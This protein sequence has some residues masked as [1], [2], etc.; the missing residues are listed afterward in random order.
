[1]G[2]AKT[3]RRKRN[4]Q[5]KTQEG[6]SLPGPTQKR[7]GPLPAAA[8]QRVGAPM[9]VIA[10]HTK[11]VISN[12]EVF[13]TVF[14]TAKAGVVPI[15][16]GSAGLFY[17]LGSATVTSNT[18]AP[19]LAQQMNGYDKYKVRKLKFTYQPVL[20]VTTGGGI[21]LYFDSNPKAPTPSAVTSISGNMGLRAGQIFQEIVVPVEPNQLSRLPEYQVVTVDEAGKGSAEVAGVGRLCWL[22]TATTLPNA[23][24]EGQIT[25]GYLWVEYTVELLNPSNAS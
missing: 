3:E 9:R 6:S 5:R 21:L 2:N 12:R 14:G 17:K 8:T 4:R 16:G 25:M 18:V 10:D 11:M 20:P 19:W 24:A 1:M 15:T 22:N 13:Y 23:T 7:V